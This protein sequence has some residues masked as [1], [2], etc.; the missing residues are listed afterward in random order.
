MG[1][2]P[3]W[4]WAVCAAGQ[5]QPSLFSTKLKLWKELRAPQ[6]PLGCKEG[7]PT[8]WGIGTFRAGTLRSNPGLSMALAHPFSY[9]NLSQSPC[10]SDRWGLSPTCWPGLSSHP[11]PLG[12]SNSALPQALSPPVPSGRFYTKVTGIFLE[13]KYESAPITSPAPTPL[14]SVRLLCGLTPG[15]GHRP[16]C[17]GAIPHY[18]VGQPSWGQWAVVL[19]W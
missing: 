14:K 1:S 19:G 8:S 2:Q 7:Q 3:D 6:P 18:Q 5:L 13:R 16:R 15:S 12:H 9:P 10:C 4:A 17:A 11:L